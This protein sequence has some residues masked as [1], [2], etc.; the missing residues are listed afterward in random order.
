M[1]L[2]IEANKARRPPVWATLWLAL[3]PVAYVVSP[4]ALF[5]LGH[6]RMW[7]RAAWWVMGFYALSQQLPALVAPEP[8]LASLLAAARTLLLLGMMGIGMALHDTQRLKPLVWGLAVTALIAVGYTFLRGADLIRLRPE[9]PYFTTVSLGLVGT[10]GLWLI[11]FTGGRLIWRVPLGAL[12]AGTLLFSGSRGPLLAALVG[13]VVALSVRFN[14]RTLGGALAAAALLAGGL[15]WAQQQDLGAVTRLLSIESSGRDLI[16]A[17]TVSV[18][19]SEPISGVGSYLL[20]SAL[21]SPDQPCQ[22]WSNRGDPQPCPQWLAPLGNPWRTA[23]NFT[24]QQLAETGPLGLLGLFVLVGTVLA[25][26]LTSRDPLSLAVVTGLLTAS[27]TDVT[28]LVPSPFFAELFW[29][30]AGLQLARLPQV[31][32]TAVSAVLPTLLALSLPT[33]VLLTPAPQSLFPPVALTFLNAPQ[34]VAGPSYTLYAQFRGPKGVYR[35]SVH[36]CAP[37]CV[38]LVTAQM[39]IQNSESDVLTLPLQLRRISR[40]ELQLR[41][42]PAESTFDPRP[43]AQK[44]WIVR[45]A[46]P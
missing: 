17:D 18:I 14:K 42:Y 20:G 15:W 5:A 37:A 31:R 30:V 35:V 34:R 9:H 26:T 13:T 33:L 7:P 32:L 4:L 45:G 44:Q 28:V 46:G 3:L 8:L 36:S 11:L 19:R 12:F 24:F 27:L 6:L 21:S 10:V 23:H 39:Q 29:M 41:L 25:A 38:T 1:P 16:W 22:L 2:P 43:L 40:Q